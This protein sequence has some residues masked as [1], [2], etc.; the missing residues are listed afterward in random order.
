MF[1][2]MFRP[3]IDAYTMCRNIIL[4]T[5][6]GGFFWRGDGRTLKLNEVMVRTP[7]CIHKLLGVCPTKKKF[8]NYLDL[9]GYLRELF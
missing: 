1:Y 4:V 5:Y 7:S 2:G 9:L 3:H 6:A 8:L